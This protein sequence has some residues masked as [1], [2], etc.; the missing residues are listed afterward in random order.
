MTMKFNRTIATIFA[1]L[2]V[3]TAVEVEAQFLKPKF[4]LRAGMNISTMLGPQEVGT[5]EGNRATILIGVAG[6]IKL[7]LN[8]RMGLI[9]EVSFIQKGSFYFKEAENSFL[10]LP[11]FNSQ[12]PVTYGYTS[13]GGVFTKRED[14]NYKKRVGMN[15]IN[16]YIEIPVL[17]YVEAIDD[18]LEFEFGPSIGFLISSQALGTL[19]FG[20]ADVLNQ[21]DPSTSEFIEMDLDYKFIQ[22][23]IG[24]IYDPE[25]IRSV[26][27]DGS[28]IA[29]TGAPGAYYFSDET[30]KGGMNRFSTVDFGLQFGTSYYFSKGLKLGF[31]LNY[32]LL[33]ITIDKYDHSFTELNSDGTYKTLN[34]RDA[35]FGCQI[36]VGLQF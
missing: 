19:K 21:E 17:F 14:K 26:K 12:Q 7:P 30:D 11:S 6:G 3:A 13:T 1:L 8:E 34:H 20:E 15:V 33:D 35:N 23:D 27:I 29:Y 16:G 2:L 25:S 32:S 28:T 4:G 22:D 24:S 36:F 10:K 18:K 5:S 9:A 31:R